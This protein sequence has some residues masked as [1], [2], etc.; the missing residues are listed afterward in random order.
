MN[1]LESPEGLLVAKLGLTLLHFLWQ[2]AA[3]GLVAFGLGIALRRATP[4]ARYVALVAVFALMAL[5]PA[6]VCLSLATELGGDAPLEG[7]TAL[8]FIV[9]AAALAAAFLAWMLDV[10]TLT[11]RVGP[12]ILAACCMGRY[13]KSAKVRSIRRKY[14]APE[15][16]SSNATAV[17]TAIMGPGAVS[18]PSN[19]QRKPSTT[20]TIGFSA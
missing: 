13:T 11:G 8:R 4:A 15:A 14:S 12:T 7:R 9:A 2:G 17:D 16:S 19:A 1:G 10:A 5:C 20:P 18:V 3:L 6:L